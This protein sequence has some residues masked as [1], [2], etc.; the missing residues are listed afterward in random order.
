[1]TGPFSYHFGDIDAHGLTLIGR[2]AD[3]EQVHQNIIA[4][5]NNAAGFWGGVGSAAH[6]DFIDNLNRN[7]AVVYDNLSVHGTKVRQ[8]GD[9]MGDCDRGVGASWGHGGG[10]VG[11]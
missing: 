6:N 4:D 10:T 5:V 1:M 8:A 2:A 3:L 11:T 7:F 9:H